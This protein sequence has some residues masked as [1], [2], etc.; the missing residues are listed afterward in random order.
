M[1][2]Q[3][4]TSKIEWREVELRELLDYEQPQD[5]IVES[6]DYKNDFKTP[7]LTAGKSFIL[8]YTN[9]T[10]GIYHKLP[11]IIFDDFTTDSR[12]I[13]FKFKVKSSAMKM[14]TSKNSCI[15]LKFVFLMMQR[16]K[17]NSSSHKRYYLSV[18][19]NKKIPLPFS[20]EKPDLKEQERIVDIL[21]KAEKLKERGEK[22][23]RLLDKY[24]KS[25][26]Y[27]MFEK[28]KKESV[29]QIKRLGEIIDKKGSI[30]CGPFGTQ[31]KI[32]EYVDTG[33]PVYG[34]DNVGVNTFLKG[35]P[36]KITLDKYKQLIYFRV[37]SNDVL[38]S[39]T[40]T[41]GRTCIAPKNVEKAVIGPNLLKVRC[42]T[43][44]ILP[45]FLS[46]MLNYSEWVKNQVKLSSPG[47]TVA[48]YNTTNLKKLRLIR[49]PLPLQQKFTKIVEFVEKMKENVKKTKDNS[50]ELFNS[51][52]SKAFRGEL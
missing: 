47:A 13:D 41:V 43:D 36:K 12:F 48:V 29:S 40:G 28:N 23:K 24:L 39:R 26:F 4:Q 6:T 17:A 8:G 16:I 15:N 49:P 5:Y 42:Q 1:K 38:I 31:L 34:I 10:N 35:K 30:I 19:Q 3:T 2:Q 52:M 50:E 27:E 25:I 32:G 11:V 45:T 22:A 18:Y 37:K 7:V 33:I 9:E 21:E 20:N 14:L 44:R 46:F 51:L